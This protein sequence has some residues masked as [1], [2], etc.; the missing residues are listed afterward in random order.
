MLYGIDLHTGRREQAYLSGCFYVEEGINPMR[1][2]KQDVGRISGD[3]GATRLFNRMRSQ[4][5]YAMSL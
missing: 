5:S 4:V 1:L 3:E 2:G